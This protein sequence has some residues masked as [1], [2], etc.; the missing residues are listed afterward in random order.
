MATYTLFIV[1]VF[2]N[3][4]HPLLF[5]ILRRYGIPNSLVQVVE[6]IYKNCSISCKTDKETINIKYSTGLQQ[7]DNASPVLF[8]YASIPRH[9]QPIDIKPSECRCF[10]NPKNGNLKALNGQLIG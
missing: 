1:K 9:P 3:V 7:G 10:K 5:N 8:A 4:Q 6:K 2:D